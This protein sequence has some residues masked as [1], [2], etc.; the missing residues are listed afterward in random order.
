[1]KEENRFQ[2]GPWPANPVQA[3]QRKTNP[4]RPKRLAQ[5]SK[6]KRKKEKEAIKT[7][8]ETTRFYYKATRKVCGMALVPRTPCFSH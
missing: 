6:K 7:E 2:N 3:G 8:Q 1:M 4:G 5:V